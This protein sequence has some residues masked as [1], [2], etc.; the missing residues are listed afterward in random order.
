MIFS[1]SSSKCPIKELDCDM[2]HHLTV[3][4]TT[5]DYLCNN[6]NTSESVLLTKYNLNYIASSDV[7]HSI[8][9]AN[10]LQKNG[11][12][13]TVPVLFSH[14]KSLSSS[15]YVA[16]PYYA[17]TLEHSLKHEIKIDFEIKKKIAFQ[18]CYAVN[19]LHTL[20]Y[21]HFKIS[22]SSVFLDGHFNA[23]LGNFEVTEKSNETNFV[24]GS[25]GTFYNMSPEQFNGHKYNFKSDSWALGLVL[26]ELFVGLKPYLKDDFRKN[27]KNYIEE[28]EVNEG[29]N[30][31]ATESSL[32]KEI[33]FK[34]LL[35]E[36][37]KRKSI[38]EI[39]SGIHSH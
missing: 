32:I 3:N 10:E 19:S 13:H 37:D 25:K 16:Y 6:K 4:F 8:E 15:F 39:I 31:P 11:A 9:I 12:K 34:Y 5:T 28:A 36:V 2:S 22:P 14:R 26:L 20:G 38:A 23:F 30:N 27:F 17:F 35:V 33:I 18:L 21:G 7:Q 29:W 1:K 24:E